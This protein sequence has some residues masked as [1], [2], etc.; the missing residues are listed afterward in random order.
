MGTGK[1]FGQNSEC[2]E[3]IIN[4]NKVFLNVATGIEGLECTGLTEGSATSGYITLYEGKRSVTCSQSVSGASGDFEKVTEI[5]VDF[6]YA[7]EI[8][9][10]VLVKHAVS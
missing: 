8:L 1:V 9:T 7:Q 10:N 6:N 5:T 3:S 2:E 4:K